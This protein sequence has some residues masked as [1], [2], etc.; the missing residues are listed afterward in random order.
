MNH[1]SESCQKLYKEY[2]KLKEKTQLVIH[3]VEEKEVK[4]QILDPEDLLRK[5]EMRRELISNCRKYLSLTPEQWI[6]LEND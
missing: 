1:S 2:L 5:E 6:E 3:S 4:P